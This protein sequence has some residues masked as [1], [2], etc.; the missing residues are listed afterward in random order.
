MNEP[1]LDDAIAR[2]EEALGLLK[3]YK[4]APTPDDLDDADTALK[5]AVDQL[6]AERRANPVVA[7]MFCTCGS[8]FDEPCPVHGMRRP[9]RP[10]S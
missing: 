5:Q 1:H 10:R 8:D 7:S 2:V 9:G 6:M 3:A 4:R